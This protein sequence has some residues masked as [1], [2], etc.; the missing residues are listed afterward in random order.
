MYLEAKD[1][2]K[3]LRISCG[4]RINSYCAQLKNWGDRMGWG[5]GE[6]TAM[7]VTELKFN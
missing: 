4:A 5:V 1:M 7:V 6:E 3:D 2:M